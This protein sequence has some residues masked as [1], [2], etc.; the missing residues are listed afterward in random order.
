[1]INKLTE[2]VIDKHGPLV[3][4]VDETGRYGLYRKND[5]E[6]NT[7]YSFSI[8]SCL[9]AMLGKEVIK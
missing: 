3:L 9:I 2:A 6:R 5:P 8:G 4:I 7:V 1:M